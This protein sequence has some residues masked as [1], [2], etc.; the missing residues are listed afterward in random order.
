METPPTHAEHPWVELLAR[1]HPVSSHF[2]SRG[3]AADG[4]TNTI[5]STGKELERGPRGIA[6]VLVLPNYSHGQ[7]VEKQLESPSG[8]PEAAQ[9]R[10]WAQVGS[11][12]RCVSS[13]VWC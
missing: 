4:R 10:P 9:A 7:W 5:I 8:G 1:R 6:G 13:P 11:A 3:P 2:F 12:R